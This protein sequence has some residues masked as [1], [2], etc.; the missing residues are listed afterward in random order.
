MVRGKLVSRPLVVYDSPQIMR[1][2]YIWQRDDWPRFRYDNQRLSAA[3][4]VARFGQGEVL[5]AVRALDLDQRSGVEL[6]A[7]TE[8]VVDTSA[9]EGE[10]LNRASARSSVARRLGLDAGGV[11]TD[12]RSEGVTAMILDATR[13]HAAPLTVARLFGWQAGLFPIELGRDP[14]VAVGRFRND[15]AGPMQVVSGR[16]DAPTVH[17]EAPPASR[18][19]AETERFIAWFEAPQ[20]ADGLLYAGLAHL[21]FVTL[22]PFDDGNGRIARAIADMALS[23]DERSPFRYVS[24]TARIAREKRAYYDQL[25]RAQRGD[26]DVTEWLA[27]FL[28]CYQRATQA[29]LEAIDR[30]LARSRFWSNAHGAGLSERQKLVLARLLEDDWE[31]N[32]TAPK[33][34]KLAKVS[35]D[36]AQRDIADLVRK[37]LLLKQPGGSKKTAYALQQFDA[38]ARR[39]YS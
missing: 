8:D 10:V 12:A 14:L 6:G 23:R 37:R 31:G 13:E 1:R 30:V 19:A 25:E 32:L 21:W 36:T 26:L 11:P 22:H 39:T 2:T 18:I 17:Y 3:L 7:R 24:M 28:H 20:H 27:W 9:I 16:I 4:A 34:A 29:T 15:A 5:G 33:Y 35:D 38:Y